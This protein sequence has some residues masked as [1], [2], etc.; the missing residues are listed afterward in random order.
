MLMAGQP[1]GVRVPG[2]RFPCCSLGWFSTKH[3]WRG[4][5]GFSPS[6]WHW[7]SIH[8]WVW[9]PPAPTWDSFS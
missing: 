2:F 8:R 9:S 5:R 7:F 1:Q 3:I 6:V 4:G